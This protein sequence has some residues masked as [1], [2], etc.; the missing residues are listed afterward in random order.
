MP[1]VAYVVES[2][3]DAPVHARLLDRVPK[4]V[5]RS[6]IELHDDYGA[7]Q[8]QVGI[9]GLEFTME[10]WAGESVRTAFFVE[11]DAPTADA[12]FVAPSVE[13]VRTVAAPATR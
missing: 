7:D 8:W 11:T 13:D 6:D 10:L 4:P 1:M 2:E 9:D 5:D 12:F 3:R